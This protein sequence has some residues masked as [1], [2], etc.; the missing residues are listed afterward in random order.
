[1]PTED[2]SKLTEK[3]FIDNATDLLVDYGLTEEQA[4]ALAQLTI[5]L[6][7]ANL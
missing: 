1:M 6:D 3:E 7:K 2:K 4:N 5:I